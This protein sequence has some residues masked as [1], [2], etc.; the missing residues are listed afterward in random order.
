MWCGLFQRLG[1]RGADLSGASPSGESMR[2]ELKLNAEGLEVSNRSY[3]GSFWI[4]FLLSQCL[5]DSGSHSP[6]FLTTEV[7]VRPSFESWL[8]HIIPATVRNQALEE[9]GGDSNTLQESQKGT[10]MSLLTEQMG[11]RNF[12]NTCSLKKKWKMEK[13]SKRGKKTNPKST[14]PSP[15]TIIKEFHRFY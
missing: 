2:C 14:C 7:K 5:C 8:S 1:K 6:S 11:G 15:K 12:G 9:P 10:W 3:R 13:H 4:T